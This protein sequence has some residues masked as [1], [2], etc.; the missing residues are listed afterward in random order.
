MRQV[1]RNHFDCQ[2][3]LGARLSREDT[4][5]CFGDSFD[6]RYHFD[7]DFTP[8]GGSADNAF[9]LS[10]LTLALLEDSGWYRSSFHRSTVPLFGR[11]A[12]CGFV[13]GDCI[14]EFNTVLP[15]YS[16]GF[17]CNDDS[18]PQ[19]SQ[20]LFEYHQP[21][22]CDYTH[23]HKADCSS[24]SVGETSCPMRMDNIESCAD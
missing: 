22:G 8:I 17:F 5:S 11:G 21:S 9:S 1:I 13:D 15:E 23:N 19:E 14:G 20:H 10:P 3:L 24:S 4:S 12:G 2:S 7:D 16:R 6:P 18:S